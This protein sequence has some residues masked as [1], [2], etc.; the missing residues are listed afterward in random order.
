MTKNWGDACG[1][2]AGAR[3]NVAVSGLKRSWSWGSAYPQPG[4]LAQ[5]T[6]QGDREQHTDQA[7]GRGA[8]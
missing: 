7:D 2:H 4:L 3:T 6:D 8:R 5:T 1:N